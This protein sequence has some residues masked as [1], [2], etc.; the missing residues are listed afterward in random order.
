MLSTGKMAGFIVQQLAGGSLTYFE[1][2]HLSQP[3]NESTSLVLVHHRQ[4]H[5]L[6]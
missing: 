2:I 4:P 5:M 3:T 1:I 6:S